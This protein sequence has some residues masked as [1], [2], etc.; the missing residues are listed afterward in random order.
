MNIKKILLLTAPAYTFKSGRDINPLPPVG[1]G[2]LASVVE[3][4]GIE[5]RI[6]DTLAHGWNREEEVNE[7]LIR[8]GLRD[9]DIS[10]YISEYGPDIVGINCQ[11]SRQNGL[12]HHLLALVKKTKPDCVTIAGGAHV[13]ACP[14]EILNDPSCD[15]IITGEAEESFREFLSAM[16]SG[17][18]ISSVDGLGWKSGTTVHLNE[19]KNWITNLDSIAFP[20]YRLMHLDLYFGLPVSH[21]LRHRKK[22][23]PIITSRGCPAKCTFCTALKVWGNKFRF[24]STQNV[25]EEMRLLRTQYGIEELM[26]ED[27]NVTANPVRA[28]ELFTGMINEKF[29][30]LW[31]TPNG[32]GVWSIDNEMLGLMKKAGCVR[33]NFPVE[34]GSQQVLKNIIKKPIDLQKVKSLIAHCR[35]IKLDYGMFLVMGMPGEKLADM[36]KSF[37]FAADCGCFFP[38]IS[39][40]TP[41]PGSELFENCVEK[42]YFSRPFTFDDLFIR[43][44]LIQTPDWNGED[45]GKTLTKGMLYLK[46]R[47][48]LSNPFAVLRYVLP[49]IKQ[50]A[51]LFKNLRKLF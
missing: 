10:D 36:R 37:K 15:F 31:D 51:L 41:Y 50:P 16:Q 17:T 23:C 25:L 2:Y 30:F 44:F 5:V 1:L 47:H 38:H 6:L 40:A 8:V 21:G 13:T 45:L 11:F 3:K 29:D 35:K 39:V 43:S 19:K 32:V 33:L 22:F 7:L 12:Y 34:S 4:M 26:F 48:I 14:H 27:D 46:F 49:Y 9:K 24:R 18:G 28:K 42:N 20:A